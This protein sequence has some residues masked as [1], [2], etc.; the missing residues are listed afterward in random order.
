MYLVVEQDDMARLLRHVVHRTLEV[1]VEHLL[2]L[3]RVF[4]HCL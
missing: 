1:H 3:F 4:G 2:N